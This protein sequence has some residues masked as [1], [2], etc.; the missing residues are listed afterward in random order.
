MFWNIGRN[1]ANSNSANG[2]MLF[3]M[4]PMAAERSGMFW[5][6]L[7]LFLMA[8][9]AAALFLTA[10]M[11]ARPFLIAAYGGRSVLTA[12]MAAGPF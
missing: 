8:P 5:D 10:P 7:P 12:A 9:M 1:S 6:V 11:A 3:L 2:G 4:A